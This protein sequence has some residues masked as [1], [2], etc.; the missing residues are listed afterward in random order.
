MDENPAPG[1]KNPVPGDKNPVP[2]D[3]NPVLQDKKW[4]VSGVKSGL[5]KVLFSNDT[6]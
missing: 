2:G 3:K 5:I 4:F 6:N 1:D